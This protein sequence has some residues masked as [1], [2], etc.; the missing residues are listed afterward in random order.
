MARQWVASL[1]S[2]DAAYRGHEQTVA[3]IPHQDA[4]LVSYAWTAEA[5]NG[6]PAVPIF[7][8]A[9]RSRNSPI[10]KHQSRYPGKITLIARHLVPST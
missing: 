9:Y 7:A 10:L 6:L 5:T 4:L 1:V 2:K 3:V 8:P